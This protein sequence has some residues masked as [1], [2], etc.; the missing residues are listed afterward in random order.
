MTIRSR[1]VNR[2][3]NEMSGKNQYRLHNV[4]Y[5]SSDLQCLFEML[6]VYFNVLCKELVVN[7]RNRK[8]TNT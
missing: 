7:N 6:S 3:R 4:W 2:E 5:P 8:L 1:Q